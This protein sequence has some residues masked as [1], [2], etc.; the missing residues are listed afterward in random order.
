MSLTPPAVDRLLA[1]LEPLPHPLRLRLMATTARDLAR[2]GRL[3]PVLA[4]LAGRGRYERRLAALGAL[5]GRHTDHLA[6]RLTDPDPV[7]HRYV[8]R[9]VRTLPVPDEAI[10]AAFAGASATLRG[11]LAETLLTGSRPAL[12]ERLVRELRA[13]WGDREAAALLPACGPEFT[14]RLLPGLAPAV[15]DWARLARRHPGPV[16][17]QAEAELAALPLALRADWWVRRAPALA[18]AAPGA[19]ERVLGL[20]ERYGPERL[21]GRLADRLDVLAAADADR[22]VRWLTAPEREN[23][24]HEPLP[25]PSVLRRIVRADPPSLPALGRRWARRP[26]H[27]AALLKAMPP[28]RRTAFHDAATDTGGAQKA[29]LPHEVLA[30]LPRDGRIAEARRVLAFD[31][32]ATG[33][34][35]APRRLALLSLLP[36][37]EAR[38]ELLAAVGDGEALVRAS[39][40]EHLVANAGHARDRAA[41]AEVLA[42]MTR[43]LR[44]DRDPVRRDAIRALAALPVSLFSDVSAEPGNA[45]H[46]TDTAHTV[47]GD[48][49]L[50][51]RQALDAP[52]CSPDT[53]ACLQRLVYTVLAAP[54]AEPAVLGWALDTLGLLSDDTRG[55]AGAHHFAD[56]P[57][58][59]DRQLVEA[60][61]PWLDRGA[62]KGDYRMLVELATWLGRRGHGLPE[63]R[64]LLAAAL[65]R[66]DD[67][68]F[69]RLAEVWLSDPATREDR[70][71]A[72]LAE[73]PSAAALKPVRQ[74]LSARRT[75]LLDPLLAAR[76]PY[77]RF[78]RES[79]DRPLPELARADRWLPR[80]QE[81]AARLAAATLADESRTPRS[82]AAVLR[83]A[84]RIP[85]LG[86]ELVRSHTRAERTVLAEAA[87]GALAR[88]DEPAAALGELLARAGEDEARVALYA[89]GRAAAGTAPDRLAELLDGLLDP[90]GDAK[91]TSRKEALRLAVRFLPAGRAA[92]TLARAGLAPDAHPDVVAAAVPLTAPLL[93]FEAVWELLEAAAA[94]GNA[95]AR[96]A[97][98]QPEPLDLAPE[99]RTRYGALVAAL[100]AS[101]DPQLSALAVHVL[102]RWIAYAPGAGE[103]VRAAVCDLTRRDR[104]WRGAAQVLGQLVRSGLDH[105]VGGA[106]PGSLLHRTVEPLLAA[107]R[108]GEEPEAEEGGDLPARQRL[109][110]LTTKVVGDDPA[111]VTALAR[112][113]AGEPSLTGLRVGL[114]VR[115]V[116]PHAEVPARL[117][118]LRELAAAHEGRP[119]LAAATAAALGHRHRRED[120]APDAAGTLELVRA[121]A[122]DGGL[123]AGLFAVALLTALGSRYGWEPQGREQL[124]ALRR[125][126]EPEVR[127]AALETTTYAE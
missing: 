120:A 1:A 117:A 43:R 77:G 104:S 111:V 87:L 45:A 118:A 11:R 123:A 60:L 67:A 121:L 36:V 13:E 102:P 44:N 15:T 25:A 42:L 2:A 5:A 92:R 115:A 10:A 7:V 37:A 96:R 68:D 112:Q 55:I 54:D 40:W 21:P 107:V 74:V 53:R 59:R 32:V 14:A 88:T 66:C 12:A 113:L 73:E 86:A 35:L 84:A 6:E 72:L 98:L 94:T 75:D 65:R 105:P 89:A 119:V 34:P 124:R 76:P 97:V 38:T 27:L 57:R 46:A 23:A 28:G 18:A 19:P 62:E 3:A 78:L 29:Q 50:V 24:W 91:V 95:A 8:R 100:T 108:A 101:A 85:D 20:L 39:G 63:V 56:L 58:G 41:L 64:E 16:L 61:R 90:A 9:A 103:T 106:A 51:A 49:A 22:L 33:K 83:G 71:A 79:A 81:A 17:D 93:A 48:L 4:D 116:D 109:Y 110:W 70:V 69:P 114:L 125:H 122:A 126:P 127:A 52:D 80:Q 47:P 99:F 26:D 30:V 82:R 31:S